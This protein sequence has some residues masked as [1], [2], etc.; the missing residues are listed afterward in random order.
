MLSA[1]LLVSLH[2]DEAGEHEVDLVCGEL[3]APG[4]EDP[5]EEVLVEADVQEAALGELVV[6]LGHPVVE[7]D[8]QDVL[9]LVFVN[10]LV[11]P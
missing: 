3:V 4:L 11:D 10:D 8:Q 1:I 9:V 2:E 6:L 5:V 7:L